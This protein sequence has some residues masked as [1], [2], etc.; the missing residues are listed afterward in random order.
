MKTKNLSARV[1]AFRT[2][3]RVIL[4]EAYPDLALEGAFK[5]NPHFSKQDAALLT[6]L[7]YGVV[8]WL[9]KLDYVI[10]LF[11]SKVKK[12]EIL[13][14]LRLGVYQLLFLDGVPDYA[15]INETVNIAKNV[16]GEKVGNFVNAVLRE[17]VREK[18]NISYPEKEHDLITYISVKDSFPKWLVE[19]WIELFGFAYTEK[20]CQS[21]NQVPPF[22]IR[23]NSL[24]TTK[25][26]LI[27]RL[28]N[29]GIELIPTKYSLDGITI[30]SKFD[31]ASIPEF[32]L[33]L[34][35]VQDEAAQLVS[36]L[37]YPK[38]GDRILDACSAPGGKTTH[39]AELMQNKGEVVALDINKSRLRLVKLQAKR[40]GIGIIK[41]V[42]ADASSGDGTKE[43]ELSFDKVLV[44][45][46]CSGLGTLKRNPDAK[47]RK[48]ERDILELSEIQFK[49]LSQ[50]S[51]ML[52]P[53][54]VIVYAVCTLMPEENERLCERFLQENSELEIDTGIESILPLDSTFFKGSGFFISDPV[55]YNM[56]GF[57]AVRFKRMN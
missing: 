26:E 6:E 4:E 15:A 11:A 45:A 8:R 23:V 7:V 41:T 42:L 53:G 10:G 43:F 16:Y 55:L 54:G 2:L 12:K 22:T 48:T 35:T 3:N 20:L 46:P 32:D 1:L 28:Q 19:R 40:L 29:R 9:G 49:I 47:W 36:Y 27:K 31:P 57:F 51:K 18:E 5:E 33:G 24:K 38:P 50:V 52:K 44:D 21:L 30:L 34:F 39:I 17:I 14:I 25:N 56:D 13:N 37:L